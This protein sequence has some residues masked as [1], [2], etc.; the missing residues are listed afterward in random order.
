MWS[1]GMLVIYLAEFVKVLLVHLG[2]WDVF[3]FLWTINDI[4]SKE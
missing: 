2:T 1:G 3:V 4:G